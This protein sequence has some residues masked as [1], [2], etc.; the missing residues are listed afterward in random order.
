MLYPIELH[1]HWGDTWGLNPELKS[2]NLP[3]YRYTSAAIKIQVQPYMV[4]SCSFNHKR[5]YGGEGRSRTSILQRMRPL[6]CRLNYLAKA[7][8]ATGLLQQ[9]HQILCLQHGR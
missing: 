3:C 1:S 6:F 9:R 5:L 8:A 7:D 4:D 2:H